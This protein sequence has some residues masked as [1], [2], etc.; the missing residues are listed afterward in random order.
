MNHRH[1]DFISDDFTSKKQRKKL[2]FIK[3]REWK[4]LLLLLFTLILTNWNRGIVMLLF[5]TIRPASAET[6]SNSS[7]SSSSSTS[8]SSHTTIFWDDEVDITLPPKNIKV[9]KVRRDVYTNSTVEI[10]R[11]ELLGGLQFNHFLNSKID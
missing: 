10:G 1:D 3:H 8:S 5:P 11:L 2:P 6:N 4:A 9:I 7:S